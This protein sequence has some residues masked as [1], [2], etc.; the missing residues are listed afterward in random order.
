[1]ILGHLT[2]TY[3]A[4]KRFE[5]V[6]PFLAR[7]PALI[8]GA[9]LPD[10]IDKPLAMVTEMPGRGIFHSAVVISLLL[11]ALLAAFPERRGTLMAIGAGAFFHILEDMSA[12]VF[13]FWPLLGGWPPIQYTG[14]TEK[15]LDY[16]IY[17]KLPYQFTIEA[18]SYPIFIW[19]LL[20][21]KVS[22][23]SAKGLEGTI[24]IHKEKNL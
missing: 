11:F 8:F 20:K 24:N 13:T 15:L 14:L 16:Y 10:L 18:V 9:Y 12:P 21:R 19:L 3:V 1:M 6:Y 4:G 23:K 5:K 22:L 17:F 2:V 7:T